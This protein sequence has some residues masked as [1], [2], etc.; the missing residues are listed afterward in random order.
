[1][2][3]AELTQVQ[4]APLRVW[5]RRAFLQRLLLP[6]DFMETASPSGEETLTCLVATNDYL[7]MSD[8][9]EKKQSKPRRPRDIRPMKTTARRNSKTNL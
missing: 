4:D 6:Q 8:R 3:S 2:A 1:M 7:N 5:S 9:V